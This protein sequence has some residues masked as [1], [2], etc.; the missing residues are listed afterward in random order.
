MSDYKLMRVDL[1]KLLASRYVGIQYLSVWQLI[2]TYQSGTLIKL[3]RHHM[4]G[5]DIQNPKL[6]VSSQ[7]RI[8]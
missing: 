3:I 7:S 4:Y 1:T 6:E 2:A 5:Q 8:F